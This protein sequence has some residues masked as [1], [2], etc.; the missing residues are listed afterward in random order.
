MKEKLN[1]FPVL[2]EK[3]SQSN[4]HIVKKHKKNTTQRS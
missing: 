2:L 3:K 1:Y 4:K